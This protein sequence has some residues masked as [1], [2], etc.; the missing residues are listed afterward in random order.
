MAPDILAGAVAPGGIAVQVLVEMFPAAFELVTDKTDAVQVDPHGKLLI[1]LLDF[2]VAGT[3]LGQSLVVQGQGE[4]HVC[5]DLPGMERPIKAP[6]LHG[7]VAVEEAVQVEE[8][9]AALMVVAVPAPGIFLVPDILKL[10]HGSGLCLVHP[11]HQPQV[12]LLAVAH[13][14]RCDLQRLVEQVIMAGDD[15]DEVADAPYGMSLPIQVDM[16]AAGSVGKPPSLAQAAQQPLQGVDI[17][18]V[19]QDGSDQFHT[20]TAVCGCKPPVLPALAADA[21]VIHELPGPPVRSPDFIGFII[22]ARIGGG[23]IE[24]AGGGIRRLFPGDAGKLRL[25]AKFSGKHLA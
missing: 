23:G 9:V 13:P 21:A 2:V 25:N 5:P 17:L 20:V 6:E 16:D 4:H 18:P 12:R 11:L 1:F 3:F 22:T 19:T 10:L 24:V 15:V 7:M 8:V 14:F